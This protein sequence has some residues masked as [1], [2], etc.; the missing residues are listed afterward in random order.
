MKLGKLTKP[1]KIT[2]LSIFINFAILY[3]V[4]GFFDLQ[5]VVLYIIIGA[6]TFQIV[7]LIN[8]NKFNLGSLFAIGMFTSV[9]Y[10]LIVIKVTGV[11]LASSFLMLAA[12]QQAAIMI[13][14]GM[15]WGIK[16]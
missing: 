13:V 9:F 11:V 10:N 2:L 16:K 15:A 1:E 3:L 8:H 7:K 5:S 4:T 12:V 6:V 14:V